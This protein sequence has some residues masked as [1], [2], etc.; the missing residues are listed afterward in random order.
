MVVNRVSMPRQR[1]FFATSL[2]VDRKKE[3]RVTYV[4]FTTNPF[5]RLRQHNGEIQG[6]AS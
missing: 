5:R 6:G 2:P 4:G 1:A 3:G